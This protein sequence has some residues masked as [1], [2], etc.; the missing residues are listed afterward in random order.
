MMTGD[1][2]VT[3]SCPFKWPAA[4]ML[5]LDLVLFHLPHFF[6]YLCYYFNTE[7]VEC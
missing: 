6:T 2:Y 5:G 3:V 1:P 7:I 4:G